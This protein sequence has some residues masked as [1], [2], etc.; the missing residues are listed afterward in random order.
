MKLETIF[1]IDDDIFFIDFGSGTP[2][3]VSGYIKRYVLNVDGTEKITIQYLVQCGGYEK[4]A[5]EEAC[6][7]TFE[8]ASLFILDTVNKEVKKMLDN[9]AK[10]VEVEDHL[11]KDALKQKYMLFKKT[12]S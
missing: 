8:E 5:D 2:T 6:F 9:N 1:E 12:L 7:S 10:L 11:I 3:I 4:W